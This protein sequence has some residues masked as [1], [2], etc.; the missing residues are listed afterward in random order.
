MKAFLV[1]SILL[2]TCFT[3]ADE[4]KS[5]DT[6][7]GVRY[8]KGKDVNFEDLLINGQLRRQDITVVTGNDTQTTDGLLRLRENFLDRTMSDFGEGTP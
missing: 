7:K 3:Y 8:K 1:L 2:T 4:D 5:A 6:Q